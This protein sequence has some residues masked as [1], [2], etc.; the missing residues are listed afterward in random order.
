MSEDVESRIVNRLQRDGYL[1]FVP[2]NAILHAHNIAALTAGIEIDEFRRLYDKK[3]W[4]SVAEFVRVHGH[5]FVHEFVN[6][7]GVRQFPSFP[8]L[9]N[10][11]AIHN[12][13]ASEISGIFPHLISDALEIDDMIVSCR[14]ILFAS[15]FLF[16]SE[17]ETVYDYVSG[18]KRACT[19][20]Y[21]KF[22]MNC[23]N[24]V[25]ADASKTRELERNA[26][27]ASW[28]SS[29]S[30]YVQL[31]TR[32]ARNV[33]FAII[34]CTFVS[35]FARFR[36][37]IMFCWK[38]ANFLPMRTECCCAID[39]KS[40]AGRICRSRVA[41]SSKIR[42]NIFFGVAFFRGGKKPENANEIW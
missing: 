2:I 24:L 20:I 11:P 5:E 26:R 8:D 31:T 21:D 41:I 33:I 39:L 18:R 6:D 14:I 13:L 22:V 1:R 12:I 42:N 37:Q 35:L 36:C 28:P 30:D 3:D 15:K 38:S 25:Q 17:I 32:L 29:V 4:N 7:D 9:W 19:T 23:I 16:D 40:F 10:V 27:L 34:C